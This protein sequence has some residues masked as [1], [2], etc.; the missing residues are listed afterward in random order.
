MSNL[1][2]DTIRAAIANHPD[3]ETGKSIDSMGQIKDI[4]V[5]GTQA[6][7]T[8]GLSSHSS[9]IADEVAEALQSKI[10]S[11]APRK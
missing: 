6:T 7:V 3:P 9:A 10:V 11:V 4:L 8:I 5:D 2:A 1:S